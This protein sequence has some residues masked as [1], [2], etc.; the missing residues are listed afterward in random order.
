L[1]A[2]MFTTTAAMPA[3]MPA[4]PARPGRRSRR[5]QGGALPGVEQATRSD[6]VERRGAGGAGAM[7]PETP[8]AAAT[9]G[10]AAGVTEPADAAAAVR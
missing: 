2:V 10:T 1:V 9:A 7:A 4:A 5:L 8:A 3:G 6:G